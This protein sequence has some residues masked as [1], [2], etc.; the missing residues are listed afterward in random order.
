MKSLRPYTLPF[1]ALIFLAGCLSKETPLV[2]DEW[3]IEITV[4][5]ADYSLE[6][7]DLGIEAEEAGLL[8]TYSVL[9]SEGYLFIDL[10]EYASDEVFIQEVQTLKTEEDVSAYLVG[11]TK[12]KLEWNEYGGFAASYDNYSEFEM[13]SYQLINGH[14]LVCTFP[15]ELEEAYENKIDDMFDVCAS[16]RPAPEGAAE[17]K[18]EAS[19]GV[20]VIEE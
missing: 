2:I 18:E 12:K 16:I 6:E 13:F 7:W 9:D 19:G 8:K 14:H 20:E 17:V 1:L 5:Y 10:Y 3:G 11:M 15:L 4:P